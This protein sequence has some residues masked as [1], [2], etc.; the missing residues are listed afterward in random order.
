M[1]QT[2]IRIILTGAQGTGKT[3]ILNQF[4][5]V[6]IT[7]ITRITE[8]AR[9]LA[10]RGIKIN[11]D[12]DDEGQISI[13]NEYTNLLNQNI[14]YISDRGLSDVLAYT[15]YLHRRCQVSDDVLEEQKQ[16]VKEFFK[17]NPDVMV[18]YFPIEFEIEDDG[19][20]SIDKSFQ[21]EIDNNIRNI[22]NE[23]IPGKYYTMSGTV[24]QRLYKINDVIFDYLY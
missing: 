11:K 18:F 8:V 20:R 14:T 9:N 21:K 12:G 10:K 5:D 15:M 23:Y 13:F 6:H 17:E 3:T 7:E 19:V 22:L 4:N 2:N 1:K 16:K 24:K